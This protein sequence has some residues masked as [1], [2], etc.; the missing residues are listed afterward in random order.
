MS[1]FSQR[2]APRRSHRWFWMLALYAAF[3]TSVA[4]SADRQ[5]LLAQVQAMAESPPAPDRPDADGQRNRPT[6]RLSA[7]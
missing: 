3:I 7:R 4:L 6:H 5:A 1:R 2:P